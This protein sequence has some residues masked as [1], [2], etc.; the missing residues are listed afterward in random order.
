MEGLE[1]RVRFTYKQVCEQVPDHPL[2][3][4]LICYANAMHRMGFST[5]YLDREKTK[6]SDTFGNVSVRLPAGTELI[7]A[8][9]GMRKEN[10]HYIEHSASFVK[11]K[12]DE[13]KVS[14]AQWSSEDLNIEPIKVLLP[15]GTRLIKSS[16]YSLGSK[17]RSHY[18]TS[19]PAHPVTGVVAFIGPGAPSSELPVHEATD[20]DAVFHG[21]SSLITERAV[22]ATI[23]HTPR[24]IKEGTYELAQTVGDL[25]KKGYRFV[26]M[27]DHGHVSTAVINEPIVDYATRYANQMR[28]IDFTLLLPN[29]IMNH[30][31]ELIKNH[32]RHF[33]GDFL[34]QKYAMHMAAMRIMEHYG[35]CIFP[36]LGRKFQLLKQSVG[37][38]PPFKDEK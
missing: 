32:D 12:V 14:P 18:C 1:N 19:F 38:A 3:D 24:H 8:P 20:A 2:L 34:P 21:H 22:N 25:V 5:D 17:D 29:I 4:T 26:E 35:C 27:T 7:I 28:K 10:F 16:G 33:Y 37:L 30:F 6:K 11:I 23:P 31:P 15:A 13:D 9:G 36:S